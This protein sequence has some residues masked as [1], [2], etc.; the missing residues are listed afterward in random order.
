[1]SSRARSRALSSRARSAKRDDEGSS[2]A[3]LGASYPPQTTITCFDFVRDSSRSI[4]FR[5]VAGLYK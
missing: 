4:D 5:L 3:R 2:F 1:V